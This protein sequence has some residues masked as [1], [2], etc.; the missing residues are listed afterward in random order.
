MFKKKTE[1][2]LGD[3]QVARATSEEPKIKTAVAAQPRL[4]A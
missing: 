3:P 1:L 2:N 4:Q